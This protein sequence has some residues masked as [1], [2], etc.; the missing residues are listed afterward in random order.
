MSRVR[1]Y[2]LAKDLGLD[3]T[4]VE[5]RCHEL[6]IEVENHLA[7]LTEEDAALVRAALRDNPSGEVTEKRVQKTVIRR[8]RRGDERSGASTDTHAPAEAAAAPAEASAPRRRVAG[9]T[10][11]PPSEPVAEEPKAAAAKAPEP[12][13]AEAAPEPEPTV[14]A[15]PVEAASAATEAPSEA[16]E[17]PAAAAAAAEETTS[18][19]EAREDG[20]AE[21][22]YSD[23]T[24]VNVPSGVVPDNRESYVQVVRRIDPAVLERS[25][26]RNER[27]PVRRPPMGGPGGPRGPGGPP[28]PGGPGGPGGFRGPGGPGGPGAPRGGRDFG[29]PGA[30]NLANVPMADRSDKTGA[31]P[32]RKRRKGGR[33]AYDRDKQGGFDDQ[34]RGRLRRTSKRRKSGVGTEI[35]IPKASKRVVKMGETVTVGELAAQLS[36]K[37]GAI[38]KYLMQMGEM[39][40]VNHVLDM[41]TVTLIAQEYEFTVENVSFNIEDYIPTVD[42]EEKKAQRRAPVVTV[43]GH[44]DHGKTSLL[45]RI[46]KARVA[47]GEAGGITQHI[48]AYK[49]PVTIS[50]VERHLVFLDTPG[51]AAFTAM[52][53]RG[54]QV[55]DVVILVVAADDGVMPQTAEAISHSKA[56]GV[57]IV[58]A[59][60]KIDKEDADPQRVRQGLTEYGLVAEEW[61]GEHQMIDVSALTGQGI[62]E[63]LE[64]VYLQAELL[65]LEAVVDCPA[66]GVVVEAELSRGRGPVATV[67]IERG[68]LR[69]GDIIVAGKAS[70]RV[71]ALVDDRGE[72]VKEAGP[73]DPVTVLGLDQVPPPSEKFFV[74]KDDKDARSIVSH[75]ETQDRAQRMVGERKRVSLED[76]QKLAESGEVK[77][78]ALIVKSDVQGS[79][80]ALRTAFEKLQHPE[81]E[82]RI[83]HGGVGPIS[84]S[85][86]SLAT[87]SNAIIIGFN[88]R[89][90]KKAKAQAEQDGV[91][92]RLYSVIYDAID[93]VKAAMEGLLSPIIEESFLGKAEVREVFSLKGAGSIAGCAVLQGKLTRNAKARLVR[94]GRLI[95]TGKVASLRRFKENVAEVDR[96]HECGVRLENY[97]D[98]KVG[99]EI[100]CFELVEIKQKLDI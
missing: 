87:A 32:D 21:S 43:M 63:L 30:P 76:L 48:G 92:V 23:A 61:G 22:S 93:D 88:V 39:V 95:Y 72:M 42:A 100:E 10:A 16:A 89:P 84:E 91:E 79:L 69:T 9:A 1:V 3:H 8:R 50:G 60:N 26:R 82:V 27:A 68:T 47:A 51:H 45:D 74:V 25:Q 58:V 66:A 41:D 49:V 17:P 44:V 11:P 14:E 15:P 85:D 65:D 24:P 19:P 6:G 62:P 54:A 7:Q 75:V 36:V 35:T 81:L 4:V 55:T 20:R 34:S 13:E 2:E 86:V 67:L 40:T 57:P 37:A 97:S 96:G 46:R 94:D 56:A 83:I 29:G 99:D 31:A 90:E 71:R 5:A 28:G 59:V 12:V 70:G 52:R 78:L 77:T 98:V 38:I 33:V 80:E 64:A 53:A 73:S 18:A